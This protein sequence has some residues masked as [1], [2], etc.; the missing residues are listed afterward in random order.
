VTALQHLAEGLALRI[1]DLEATQDSSSEELRTAMDTM[2]I[3]SCGVEI[4]TMQLGFAMLEAG[5]VREQNVVATYMKNIV[6][7]LISIFAATMGSYNLA[8]PLEEIYLPEVGTTIEHHNIR[9]SFFFHLLF[10]GTAATIVSG[11]MA[12]RVTIKGYMAFS[13]W[14]SGLIYPL[15]VRLTWG[16]GCLSDAECLGEYFNLKETFH[17]FAGSG[18]VHLV[19]GSAALVG[20]AIIGGR[21]GRWDEGEAGKFVPHDL[22][23]V[24]SGMLIL[25]CGWYGFNTGSSLALSDLDTASIVSTAFVSTTAA[26]AGGGATIVVLSLIWTKGQSIDVLHMVNGILG[27]LVAI[28]AGCDVISGWHAIVIGFI[29]AILGMI[30]TTCMEKCKVDD[31]CDAI[32]VHGAC[33]YFGLIAVGLFSQDKGLFTVGSW[34]L[35]AT[36]ALGGGMLFCLSAIPSACFLF[37]LKCIKGLRI[38]AVEESL[39]LDA[40]LGFR[41]YVRSSEQAREFRDIVSVLESCDHTPEQAVEALQSLKKATVLTLTPQA[42][43]N[44]LRGELEDIIS[45]MDTGNLGDEMWEFFSFLSHHK[46]D[47]GEVARVFIEGFRSILQKAEVEVVNRFKETNLIFL[48]SNNLRDLASL[49]PRVERTM[50]II[51]LLTRMV[52]KRPWCIAEITRAFHAGR[53]ILLVVVEW[54]D[55]KADPRSFRLPQDLDEAINDIAS[56][57]ETSSVGKKASQSSAASWRKAS[58]K[59]LSAKSDGGSVPNSP[60]RKPSMQTIPAGSDDEE[61][62][63]AAMADAHKGG[64][65]KTSSHAATTSSLTKSTA[66][67]DKED[68]PSKVTSFATKEVEQKE[69]TP[70]AES[71]A[72]PAPSKQSRDP[73]ALPLICP[74]PIPEPPQTLEVQPVEPKE[75]KKKALMYDI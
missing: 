49:L 56:N 53:R 18:V 33:G 68:S 42:A 66:A 5:F 57:L 35:L 51:V 62:E 75:K 3:F 16:G 36:Q 19:G 21:T 61:S 28:T 39:G 71:N 44:K 54:P 12:E 55:K 59:N 25:W 67:S 29:S 14:L 26:A 30:F 38:D 7:F 65:G 8:Y 22:S 11:A 46:K 27:G 40:K 58:T 24:L 69:A 13:L 43:D 4:A 23:L 6:D 45:H 50:N 48:D 52:L 70:V 41:A 20:T 1:S 72:E 17:D 73:D 2:W 34:D 9:T 32:G 64:V 10:Q 74:Q 63:A 37:F 15:A 31:V 47:G 60:N